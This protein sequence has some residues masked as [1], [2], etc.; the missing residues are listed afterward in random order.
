MEFDKYFSNLN[1]DIT[2]QIRG[3]YD[4]GE[5][6][7]DAIADKVEDMNNVVSNVSN[8][9]ETSKELFSAY[10]E[11]VEENKKIKDTNVKLMYNS[12]HDKKAQEETKEDESKELDEALKGVDVYGE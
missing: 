8:L 10:N 3:L 4:V 11:L 2:N 6:N 1:D 5:E 9:V 12:I 7:I